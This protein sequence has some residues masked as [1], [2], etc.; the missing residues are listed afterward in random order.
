M[1]SSFLIY[2]LEIS[3]IDL[4]IQKNGKLPSFD[5]TGDISYN[6]NVSV[7]GTES[8]SGSI[9]ATLSI[10]IYQKGIN[11]S[12]I[13][14]YKSK[15]LQSEFILDD[16]I[17][18]MNLEISTDSEGLDSVIKELFNENIDEY[19]R[20]QNGEDKLIKF[21]MGQIMKKTKGKYPPDIIVKKL[22]DNI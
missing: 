3:I 17:N 4:N 6:D 13:R 10:P 2:N 1:F 22:K 5:L 19:K 16:K 8:T 7:K 9:S 21:F 20:L 14:K 11:N 15:L 18:D 12:N